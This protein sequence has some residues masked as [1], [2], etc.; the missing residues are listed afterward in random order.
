MHETLKPFAAL[1][2]A[3]LYA[4]LQLR[5]EIFVVEQQCAYQDMDGRDP[6]CLHWTIWDG[7]RAVSYVRLLPAGLSFDEASIGRVVTAQA[8][9]G[10]GLS[11]RLMQQAMQHLF[12]EWGA[13]SIRIGAQRY[14]EAFYGSLGFVPDSEPY[15]EDGIPHIEMLCRRP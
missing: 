3:E 15:L 11:R 8:Y 5:S 2:P 10:Q 9:R 4:I 12:G 6:D 14:L 13:P 7:P 1:A